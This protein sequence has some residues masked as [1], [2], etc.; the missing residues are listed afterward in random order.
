MHSWMGVGKVGGGSLAPPLL[1]GLPSG[2]RTVSEPEGPEIVFLLPT[3]RVGQ[4]GPVAAWLN[5]AGWVSAATRLG[6]QT[7]V[8]TS[9]GQVQPGALRQ[10]EPAQPGAGRSRVA[11]LLPAWLKVALKDGRELLRSRAFLRVASSVDLTAADIAFVWQ[12]HELFIRAGKKLSQ[13]VGRPLV[14]FVASP[15]IWEADHWGVRRPGWRALAEWFGDARPLRDAD[16]VACVSREVADATV[17]L[18]VD[19]L[20]TIV[21]PS[22]VDTELFQPRAGGT[23]LR[24]TYGVDERFVVIWTGSFRPFHG[25]ELLLD[26]VADASR[27]IPS[28]VLLLVGDGPERS[29]LETEVVRRGLVDLVRFTGEISHEEL[30][31]ILSVADMAV[32]ASQGKQE[33]HYSPLKLWEYLAM[34]LPVAAP[35]VGEPGRMLTDHVDAI[36]YPPGNREALTEAIVELARS[37]QTG[38]RLGETARRLAESESWRQQLARVVD[39][40]GSLPHVGDRHWWSPRDR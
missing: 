9:D 4:H 22:T 25:L 19:P 38:T 8:V 16:V 3:R 18:G 30:P 37:P 29:R 14:I 12:R 17:A 28:L 2:L 39:R 23:E 33:F 11:S 13:R 6:Y 27:D 5:T 26:S 15:K 24:A 32:V 1:M 7:T 31:R 10:H 34:G 20:R 35:N 21:T 40:L 36:L